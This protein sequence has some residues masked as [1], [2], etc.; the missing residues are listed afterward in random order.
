MARLRGR[1]GQPAAPRSACCPGTLETAN[2]A[3]ASLNAAFP[4]TRAFAREI[5]PGVHETPATIDASFPWVA[6]TRK[7]LSQ[8]ELRG[9]A[10]DLAP[11]T[12]R[13]RAA[14]PTRRSKLLPEINDTARCARDVVLPTGDIVVQDAFATG[15]PNYKEFWQALVG[16]AGEGQNFDG[17]GI[18][19]RFQTGGGT[20]TVALGSA[21]SATGKLVGD[22]VRSP[23]SACGR[24]TRASA[25][26]TTRACP[27]T[28]AR[29]RT[30]TGRRAP[31]G[32]ARGR[33]EDRDPQALL[34]FVAII[35][36]IVI[37][38]AVAVVHPRQ[39][40]AHAARLGAAR[41]QGL[42]R[43]QG[44]ARRPP[45]R[46]RRARA[47]RSTSPASRSAR[48]RASS[49]RTARPSSTMKIAAEV[50]PRLPRRDRCCCGPRPA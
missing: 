31:A 19:V 35:G 20:N 36:L 38:G 4:P 16:L 24:S 45:R 6:Q 27:V 39:P 34:D 21:G 22:G 25:R 41:R 40:A 47:R 23:C 26:R 10:E 11:T 7:L 12:R 32:R 18:Y 43:A 1:A 9:L 8:A 49:S 2:A 29:S 44:R 42:L 14:R 17:N 13:P 48:S 46:S 3:L 37:A 28:R 30:S 15:E 50:Q 33:R 5:L